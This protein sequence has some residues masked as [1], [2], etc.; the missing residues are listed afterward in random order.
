MK[1]LK[2]NVVIP[3]V[4]GLILALIGLVLVQMF[5]IHAWQKRMEAK[6]DALSSEVRALQQQVAYNTGVLDTMRRAAL[7]VQPDASESDIDSA[8]DWIEQWV[9][10]LMAEIEAPPAV[11]VP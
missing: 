2:K 10:L 1:W 8:E 7:A 11:E 6:F 4:V 9:T 3:P 5:M